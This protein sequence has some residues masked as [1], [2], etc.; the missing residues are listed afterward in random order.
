MTPSPGPRAGRDDCNFCGAPP[1]SARAVGLRFCDS[2]HAAAYLTYGR[3][4]EARPAGRQSPLTAVPRRGVD[5]VV[6]VM[7]VACLISL[8]LIL[9]GCWQIAQWVLA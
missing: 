2:G 6:V 5:G 4:S 3:L 8:T 1:D 9:I 7:I